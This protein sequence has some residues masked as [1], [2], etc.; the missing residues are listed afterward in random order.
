[1]PDR[2][3]NLWQKLA[4]MPL[5]VG[6][7]SLWL[8]VMLGRTLPVMPGVWLAVAC[9]FTLALIRSRDSSAVHAF[10]GW[11]S[12]VVASFAIGVSLSHASLYRYSVDS[13]SH[14]VADDPKLAQL[15]LHIIE[16]PRLRDATFGLRNP[17]PPRLSTFARA[18]H[19]LTTSGWKEVQGDV[20]VQIAQVHPKLASGQRVQAIGMLDRPAEAANP[21]QFDF[22][23]YYRM[24]RVLVSFNIRRANNIKILDD[25]GPSFLSD[26][27]ESA[28]HL[29]AAGF[30]PDHSLDLSLIRALVLGDYD[31][32]LRDVRDQ[33]RATGTGHHLAI[34]GMHV[35]IVGGCVFVLLRLLGM[36]PR[37]TWI[38]SSFVVVIYGITA[39]PS[40]PVWRSV[41]LFMF[42]TGAFS[43]RRSTPALQLLAVSVAAMLLWHP[44][45]AFNAGFQLSFGT[46]L[47]MI[48]LT[49]PVHAWMTRTRIPRPLAELET[50]PAPQ[51][52]GR[53]LDD[54]IIKLL[55]AGFVAWLVSMPLVAL[56][57]DQLNPW[58][59]PASI[60]LG[61]I[62]ILT[63]ILGIAKILVT[64]ALPFM[65]PSVADAAAYSSALMRWIVDQLAKLPASD[66]P[67]PAPPLWLACACWM[68]IAIAAFPFRF[69][70]LR[71]I[72]IILVFITYGLMLV[73]PYT[74]LSQSASRATEQLGLPD[75]D[76]RITMLHVGAGQAVLAE[77]PGDR[78]AMFDV[79]TA[80]MT[81]LWSQLLQ[82]FL[83]SRG[84]TS[85][86]R[87]FIS[88][89]NTDHYSSAHELASAY[90][91]REVLVAPGFQH[92]ASQIEAGE[93]LL[94]TLDAI[95]LPPRVLHAGDRVPLARDTFVE[96]LWPPRDHELSAN[97]ASSVV[98]L[99]HAGRSIL[100]TGDIQLSAIQALLDSGI[101]LR[102]D[103]LIAPHHGSAEDVTAEFLSRVDPDYILASSDR[104]PSSK[105]IRFD[106]I[107]GDTP[108]FRTN[109]VGAIIIT[110]DADGHI[111]ISSHLK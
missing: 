102:A 86:D 69:S 98:R 47:G 104:S 6:A 106:R 76:L 22:S 82:P 33:F 53:K 31:P 93:Q 41:L 71:V 87:L 79:G 74:N 107:V 27:R 81:D 28:R 108:L 12:L 52:I 62:V 60:I 7:V 48:L 4:G 67:L 30:D 16:A 20:L 80:S 99:T 73:G 9:L 59:V 77:L 44:L 34:S 24:Q 105:Q 64:I 29:L 40:P 45:D 18:T 11:A 101:D 103:V 42:A 39:M 14:Y 110:I 15:R 8:A 94:R 1:M 25:P 111:H 43:L 10:F 100:F 55:A 32:Q 38:T 95:N 51:R 109:R 97:D 96:S 88:H 75:N 92:H 49:G 84:V 56:H 23:E 65:A 35:A 63:L 36:G 13:I 91:I 17:V 50:L 70:G 26:W 85:I 58:Q 54:G 66:V 21:G 68:A 37:V 57:F 3:P 78:Q 89:A 46:V 19:V 90:N 5:I 61:P 72:G 2:P 83:R